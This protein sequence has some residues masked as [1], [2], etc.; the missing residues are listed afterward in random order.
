MLIPFDLH[1]PLHL[2]S[3]AQAW[4]AACAADWAFSA[5][6]VACNTRPLPN[7]SQA[8]QLVLQDGGPVGF[9]L[10]SALHTD[11]P[12]PIGWVDALAVAPQAQGQ[13]RGGELLTWAESWLRQQGCRK[14]RLGGSLRPFTHGLPLDFGN[15][16]FFERRGY[17]RRS[18]EPYEWDVARDL[19]NYTSVIS[20][21][22][23]GVSARPMQ[24]GEEKE[25]LAFLQREFPGRWHYEAEVFVA[26][27]GRPSDFVLLWTPGG[28]EGFCRLTREDSE[29]PI[30]RFYMHRLPRPWGQLGPLGVGKNTRGKGYGGYVIDAALLYLQARGVAGCVIDWTTL[31]ELYARFGFQPYHQYVTLLKEL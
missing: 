17:L 7:V 31:L 19:R 29:R 5:A 4:T 30:E 1:N 26:D 16:A 13:G 15:E 24:A 12:T 11:P 27:G 23:E 25:L 22:P 28:V 6:T 10:A 21:P 9:I 3:A 8:G 18:S 20:T 2:N 14:A